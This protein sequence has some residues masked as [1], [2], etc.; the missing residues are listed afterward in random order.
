MY[1]HGFGDVNIQTQLLK[2][3]NG[4]S[5]TRNIPSGVSRSTSDD[6]TITGT[7]TLTVGTQG[8]YYLDGSIANFRLF[9]KAL[10]ADQV[11][12]LYAYDAVRFG[13]RAS[14]SVSVHKGNL[15]VGVTAPTS[16]FEVAPAD[17][18]F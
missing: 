8:A 6:I 1:T 10:S 9:S 11:K 4:I 15:G 14:N 13:H 2:I 18:V 17:G 16:R 7:N 12:E 5:T 3:V